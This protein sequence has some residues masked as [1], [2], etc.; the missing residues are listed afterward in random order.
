MAVDLSEATDFITN[1]YE[2]SRE[3]AQ[4][5]C[6]GMRIEKLEFIHNI[7]KGHWDPTDSHDD[8][9]VQPKSQPLA[10]ECFYFPDRVW[11]RALLVIDQS[12]GVM[13]SRAGQKYY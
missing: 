12:L 11:V 3:L 8:I 5:I 6:S 9:P 1:G 4:A 7:L 13:Q 2:P 10:G